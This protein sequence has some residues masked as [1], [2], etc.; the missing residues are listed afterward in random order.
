MDDETDLPRKDHLG[1]VRQVG[2]VE[3]DIHGAAHVLFREHLRQPHVEDARRPV[4]G[5]PR[6]PEA[7]YGRLRRGAAETEVRRLDP[8]VELLGNGFAVSWTNAAK[9]AA[10]GFFIAALCIFSK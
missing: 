3:L 5:S 7:S 8:R 1:A 6:P 9:A 10:S 2:A 4:A